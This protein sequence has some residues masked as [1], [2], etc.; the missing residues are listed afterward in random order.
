MAT[1]LGLLEK[2]SYE[3]KK[4]ACVRYCRKDFKAIVKAA[5]TK[6]KNYLDGLCLDC[7]DKSN[8][9]TGNADTDYW[10]HNKL[11]MSDFVR[12]CR[13]K[14]QEP[15]WY[16]SFMGRRDAMDRFQRDQRAR[17]YGSDSD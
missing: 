4:D 5:Q 7:M 13:I 9:V 1:V 16:F 15:T 3:A 6:T 14:H 10:K 12:D 11:D 17:M 8:P 2:F